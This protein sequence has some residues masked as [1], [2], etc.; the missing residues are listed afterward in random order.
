LKKYFKWLKHVDL[1]RVMHMPYDISEKLKIAVTT[2][3]I[4]KLEKENEI[5]EKKGRAEYEK[6]QIEH[7]DDI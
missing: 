5:F 4:F 3:A 1:E 6:Y 7:E 2:R